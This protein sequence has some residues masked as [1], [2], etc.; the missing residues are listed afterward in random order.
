MG[1]P[2]LVS[3]GLA[4]MAVVIYAGAV[5]FYR[6]MRDEAS[7]IAWP[8]TEGVIVAHRL[9]PNCSSRRSRRAG[10]TYRY[11]VNSVT[12]TGDRIA[13]TSGYCGT[14][15]WARQFLAETYPIGMHVPV[16][17]APANHAS[18]VLVPGNASAGYPMIV[19]FLAV[20]GTFL[21]ALAALI[22]KRPSVLSGPGGLP[23]TVLRPG[24][25]MRFT[26]KVR[27]AQR[28]GEPHE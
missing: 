3:I 26:V 16:R 2:R 20:F 5:V 11:E 9:D 8:T 12:Y 4:A 19:G 1:K 18:A 14:P 25:R 23:V 15:D 17:Y 10:V 7:S 13:A 27:T 24:V 22:W 28:D 21:V 6:E